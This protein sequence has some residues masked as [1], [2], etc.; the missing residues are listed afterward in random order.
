MTQLTNRLQSAADNLPVPSEQEA[1]WGGTKPMWTIEWTQIMYRPCRKSNYD[2]TAVTW[3]VRST[4]TIPTELLC[5]LLLTLVPS[6]NG[7]KQHDD[8]DDDDDDDEEEEEEEDFPIFLV[9]SF[10]HVG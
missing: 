8:D 4:L 2:S 3:T 7:K 9:S 10:R 5:L 1:L 6:Y